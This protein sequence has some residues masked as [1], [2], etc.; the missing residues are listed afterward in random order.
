MNP[1]M[2]IRMLSRSSIG[3]K[4]L[5]AITGLVLFGFMVAH[6]LGNLLVFAGPE[7]LNAY[8]LHLRD[9]GP[10][11]WVARGVL[12]VSILLHIWVSV[13]LTRENRAAR[14]ER[15]VVYHPS[16]TTYAARTMMLSGLLLLAYLIYHRLHFTFRV[17][18]PSAAHF[19]DSLGRHD[20]YRMVVLGFQQWPVVLI[21]VVGVGM[22]CLHVSHGIG[23]TMQTLG[24]NNE[25]TIALFMQWG[26]LFALLIFLG[27]CSIPTAILLGAI[28]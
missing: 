23:S 18:N 4:V 10:V 7:A 3:K 1:A 19:T 5:M 2:T 12:L 14:R 27:Y 13:R 28:H 26:R 15:Y 8:A 20:V 21:Y 11:L 6:L 16:A 24:I 25:R 9:L 17:I 22:V